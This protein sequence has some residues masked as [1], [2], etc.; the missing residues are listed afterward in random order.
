MMKSLGGEIMVPLAAVLVMAGPVQARDRSPIPRF[1]GARVYTVNVEDSFSNLD[2]TIR[3]LE[4][5]SPQT[6][7]VVV[8]KSF[9][10]GPNAAIDYVDDLYRAWRRQASDKKIPLDD[11]RSV[12]TVIAI[13]DRKLAVHPGSTL[14][15]RFGLRGA[16]IDRDL[17]QTR[18][19][20]LAKQ[21]QYPQAITALLEGIGDWIAARE[22][23]S[24][25]TTTKSAAPPAPHVPGPVETTRPTTLPGVVVPATLPVAASQGHSFVTGLLVIVLAAAVVVG[26]VIWRGRHQAKIGLARRV[27]DYRARSVEVMDRLDALKDRLKRL[28]KADPDFQAPS[29]GETLALF[30][31]LE[32]RLARLWDRW[33]AAM[34]S[35][36][37]G[38]KL[39]AKAGSSFDDKTLKQVQP[40]LDHKA[41]FDPI[42]TDALACKAELD[43]LDQAH[44]AA[45]EVAAAIETAIPTLAELFARIQA[46][47]LPILP[48][49]EEL[50]EVKV[51]AARLKSCLTPDPIGT[52][53]PLE[54][55]AARSNAL[56]IRARLTIT[57]QGEMAKDAVRLDQV[58][59]QTSEHRSRG[60]SLSEDGGNPDHFLG[61]AADHLALVASALKEG[62]P[63]KGQRE[64]EQ[65]RTMLDQA[66][67]TIEEVTKAKAFCVTELAARP[68]ETERLRVARP[69]AESSFRRL[70]QEFAPESWRAVAKNL[71][72][73]RALIATFDDQVAKAANSAS[74]EA[75]RYLQARRLLEEL[76]RRQQIVLRLLSG[77]GEQLGLLQTARDECQTL[78]RELEDRSREVQAFFQTNATIVGEIAEASLS[79]ATTAAHE[80]AADFERARPD[81]PRLRERI[82]RAIEDLAIAGSQAETDVNTHGQL[83][84][85]FAPARIRADQLRGRLAG[86]QEDRLAANQHFQAAESALDQV[87][88]D[89]AAPRGQSARMLEAVR[90]ALQD[91]DRAEQLF[92]EDLRLAAQARSE[93][94]LATSSI[95]RSRAYF[96]MGVAVD[97]AAAESALDQARRL[98]N[99]QEY[100]QA[101]EQAGVANRTIQEAYNLAAQQ[102][103][104]RR[105]R[106]QAD[107][108][109]WQ[110][111]S[112]PGTGV[113]VG[114]IAAVA[115]ASAILGHMT[116]SAPASEAPLEPDGES[117]AGSWTSDDGQGSW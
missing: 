70:E 50:E 27:K 55:L 78:K 110:G 58:K 98:M 108:T 81:W 96:S 97:G 89:L 105:M 63:E 72:Q 76:A 22:R 31:S 87:G 56:T 1:T 95:N 102:A 79:K 62:E 29:M 117:G 26:I 52:K 103:M 109:R 39:A 92:R 2:T 10:E 4:K 104:W 8:V 13:Q 57:L 41:A 90:G 16:T 68:R 12:V 53:P 60:L 69:E 107:L 5:A 111:G 48:F 116:G 40:L 80:I 82:S 18:F 114:T 7:Y 73:A 86:R 65:A 35:L 25:S 67:A 85:E 54:R 45:R 6:Y 99:D 9:G 32:D 88:I 93:I 83:T 34:E 28:S 115:A 94:D 47:G 43:R 49:Q 112:G 61:E 75:Q 33:L 74:P 15:E 101:I 36:D 44:E 84:A 91:L 100:E 30:T 24:P 38:Q 64:L 37:K 23:T 19:V 46:I 77:L 14:R 59:K 21:D 20:P 71:E 106:Q 3:K 17:I 51:E 42:E 66:Q 11:E 113:S